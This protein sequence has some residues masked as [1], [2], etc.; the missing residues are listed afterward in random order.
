MDEKTREALINLA[1]D[2]IRSLRAAG[3]CRKAARKAESLADETLLLW[4]S[5]TLE[6]RGIDLYSQFVE[7]KAK[8]Y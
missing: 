5:A 2:A 7:L 3:C 4:A 8:E 1:D 6:T